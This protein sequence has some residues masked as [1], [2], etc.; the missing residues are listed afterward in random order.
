MNYKGKGEEVEGIIVDEADNELTSFR[1]NP[2]GMGKFQLLPEKGKSYFGVIRSKNAETHKFPIP[3]GQSQGVAMQVVDQGPSKRI[4]LEAN[5]RIT[6]SVFIK[7]YHRGK[8]IYLLQALMKNESLTYAFKSAELPNGLIGATLYNSRHLPIAERH[9]YNHRPET[10]LNVKVEIDKGEY[11]LRDSII[12]R[13]NTGKGERQVEAS[14]SL[15]VVAKEYFK[16][17]NLT[18]RNILSYLLLES[19]IKGNI[20]N[21]AYYFE[22]DDHLRDLDY[23]MLTQ[24]WT[25]Y[26][27]DSPQKPKIVQPEKGLAL[28]GYIGGVQKRKK[29]KRFKDEKFDLALMTFGESTTVYRQAIDSTGYFNFELDD[30]YGE[31]KKFVIQPASSVR[32][33][34]TF[35]V[36]LKKR[37]I[38]EIDYIVEEI[39]TPVDTIIEKTVTE[40]IVDDIAQDPYLLPNTIALDEVVVSDYIM[41]PEREKM[42]GLHGMPDVVIDNKE[43][44]AKEKNWTSQLYKWLLFNYPH[45][46]S[47]KKVGRSP[48]FL[49]ASVLG[50]GF[51]YVLVDGLPVHT[52]H[53]NLIPELPL[54]AVKSV[55][56]L[57][58]VVNANRYF[59]KVFDFPGGSLLPYTPAILAIYTYSGKGLFG[60]FPEKTNLL[61][62]ST[63]E[64]SPKR[65]FYSPAYD[66][67]DEDPETPDL[68]RLIH[69]QADVRTDSS[70][71]ATVKF[72]NGDIPGEVLIICEGIMLNESGVGRSEISY[73]IIE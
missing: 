26:K 70:G 22:D 16:N 43:L 31:G 72:F 53:Y 42:K 29:G 7:L 17:T 19:D 55:E 13:L 45:E 1:S 15:M 40:R 9:F 33:N 61:K 44:L 66:N 52:D 50:A 37:D 47:I 20:E 36:N 10:N 14:V 12:V 24:G 49:Y 54:K 27:Y 5:P 25:N 35:K 23:L 58:N 63:P 41:T 11:G 62:A 56:I 6:D 4:V 51:T 48:S 65:E 38:P 69:W 21:P 64:F 71:K 28:S 68:R 8:D 34:A 3:K 39:I 59:Y 46:L 67:P 60:A 18:K 2:L 30:S 32:K 73:E 57:K